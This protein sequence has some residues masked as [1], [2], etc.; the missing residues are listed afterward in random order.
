MMRTTAATHMKMM[1]RRSAM[2]LAMAVAI[3][4]VT[5]DIVRLAAK[6]TAQGSW[7]HAGNAARTGEMPGPGLDL[8]QEIV[9]LWRTG[10]GVSDVIFDPCGVCDGIVYY[11]PVPNGVSA[12]VRPL[13][14]ID[15]TSGVQ[16]WTHEPPLTD[17][18]SSFI[19]LPAIAD[20]MLVMATFGGLL[21]AMDAK[22]GEERWI[23]DLQGKPSAFHPAILDGVVYVS[24][25]TSVNA[26]K[27]GDTP[28]WLWKTSLADGVQSVVSPTVSVDDG[29][30][31]VSS[32]SPLP[33]STSDEKDSVIHVLNAEDGVEAYR[34]QFQTG[35]EQY[36]FAIR[37]GVLY[38]RS[39]NSSIGR[40]FIFSMAVDGTYRWH[41]R[42]SVGAPAYPAVSDDMIFVVGGE[43]VFGVNPATGE[44]V[45]QSP[46][47]ETLDTDLVVIDG[48]VYV[49]TAPP[50]QHV[51]AL[52]ASDGSL[53]HAIPIGDHGGRVVG[54][55]EGVLIARVGTHLAAY[56]NV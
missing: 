4:L 32:V 39:D 36:Q 53:S 10:L 30:V 47:L 7:M 28:E 48:A 42:T 56:G 51:Y 6:E 13:I 45:W 19:G 54:V 24:D 22:T 14:A 34:Y 37:D 40:G 49:G 16:L 23:F 15:A 38:S 21:V 50:G 33:G 25:S 9:E 29:F 8:D 12:E 52:S 3:P 35:G 26:V 43:V 55:T 44:T 46:A 5:T 2:G 18:P 27:S 1:S 20:G 41:F 11:L 31:V 17:P